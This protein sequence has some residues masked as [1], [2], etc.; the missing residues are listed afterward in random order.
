M[1]TP[2]P[3]EVHRHGRDRVHRAGAAAT[4]VRGDGRQAS[5]GTARAP[6]AVSRSQRTARSPRRVGIEGAS[7]H[8]GETELPGTFA[9]YEQSPREYELHVAQSVLRSTPASPTFST[10][11]GSGGARLRLTIEA[12][13]ERQEHELINNPDIGLL[14]DADLT[15][16]LHTRTGPPTSDDFDG[17]LASVSRPALLLAHPAPS[18]PSAGECNPRGVYPADRQRARGPAWRGVP[19]CPATRSGQPRRP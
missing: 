10:T 17:W 1:T 13:R 5:R 15:Q 11:H 14:H 9:D 7:G 3:V 6:Q 18:P 2:G 16:R 19:I 12:L 8:K 4:G